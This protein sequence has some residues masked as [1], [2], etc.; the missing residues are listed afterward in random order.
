MATKNITMVAQPTALDR[1][2][3][4]HSEQN[5][6][7]IQRHSDLVVGAY[8]WSHAMISR[9]WYR[10]AQHDPRLITQDRHQFDF[11][12]YCRAWSGTREY[13][14]QFLQLLVQSDL[15][16]R[17]RIT[18][19]DHDQTLHYR[20]HQYV[21][22]DFVVKNGVCLKKIPVTA[23]VS[24]DSSATY[25]PNHYNSCW[26]DI[27]LETLF[28]DERWYLTEKSLRP[29]A[30][31]KPFIMVATPGSLRYLRGYGFHTFGDVID[32]SYDDITD[33]MQR[34]QAITRV[35]TSISAQSDLEKKHTAQKLQ[36][37]ADHNR[38]L[39]FSDD[40]A[41]NVINE[42]RINVIKARNETL[43][44]HLTGYNWTAIHQLSDREALDEYVH[45]GKFGNHRDI[46]DL[47][48][49]C[50]NNRVRSNS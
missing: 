41:Q 11:N 8:W 49:E 28:D 45:R 29:I 30:C 1:C 34:L 46:M 21:N 13:R 6:R 40:F 47:L 36:T 31:G 42:L 15:Q 37:I 22:Q 35:M 25:D 23:Q 18:F 14:L 44:H 33:P 16:E 3:L 4:L 38:K 32:E 24:S 43:T 50:R 48:S 27:V 20:E 2:V 7:Q 5:S 10:F 9:D 39:F 19:C 12:I 17:S 26:I